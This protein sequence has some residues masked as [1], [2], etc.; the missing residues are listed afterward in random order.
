[1]QKSQ[2]LKALR[3]IR[4]FMSKPQWHRVEQII[5]RFEKQ[6]PISNTLKLFIELR[7]TNL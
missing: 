7:M 1:M 2:N 3:K 6:T 4:D 5:Y